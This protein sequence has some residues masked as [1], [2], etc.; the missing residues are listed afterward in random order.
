MLSSILAHEQGVGDSGNKITDL[1]S[2]SSVY[3]SVS[4]DFPSKN[5][6]GSGEGNGNPLQYSC[7]RNPM[8]EE[9]GGVHGV[10][11]SQQ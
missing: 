9:L 1:S 6:I 4:F 8:N 2:S 11:K 3:C 5:E 7:L 10:P